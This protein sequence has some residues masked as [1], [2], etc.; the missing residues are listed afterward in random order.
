MARGLPPRSRFTQPPE[1]S[2]PPKRKRPE[3]VVAGRSGTERR[4]DEEK[5]VD[6]E[7]GRECPRAAALRR[8]AAAT[9]DEPRRFRARARVRCGENGRVSPGESP[10]LERGRETPPR[11]RRAPRG[12]R[13]SR[14]RRLSPGPRGGK[15]PTPSSS[16][17]KGAAPAAAAPAA[18]RTSS[19][20][21]SGSVV[22]EAKRQ[23][24]LGRG[25]PPELT[26]GKAARRV[27]RG[28]RR[29]GGS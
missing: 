3:N 23:V 6:T 8:T 11:A 19:T 25:H 29:A 4:L 13:R 9:A 1:A 7:R 10:A 5:A 26:F 28:T 27:R 15:H 2:S 22:E 18:A 16:R 17:S 21:S 14:P 20:R 12:P 24:A